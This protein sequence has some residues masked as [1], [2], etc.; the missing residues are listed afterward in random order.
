MSVFKI[1]DK[2]TIIEIDD[3]YHL[4]IES[5]KDLCIWKDSKGNHHQV[6]N[7]Y[8]Y[9]KPSKDTKIFAE[10]IYFVVRGLGM[11]IYYTHN[12]DVITSIALVTIDEKSGCYAKINYIC[13]NQT[14]R[15]E[16]IT[17]FYISNAYFST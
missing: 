1:D 7:L 2:S 12:N 17:P 5:H 10:D 13:G 4:Y 11:T 9:I 6:I 3:F 15:H 14:T 16:K 8:E